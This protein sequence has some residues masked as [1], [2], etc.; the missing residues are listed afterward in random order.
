MTFAAIGTALLYTLFLWWFSTGAI[1][2]LDRRPRSTHRLSLIGV[3]AVA[4][5]AVGALIASLG[6]ATPT[7]AM[8]GFTAAVLIWGWHELSFLTGLITGPRTTICPPDAMGWRRFR[9]AASTLIH[10]EIAL[11]LTAVA[12][13]V[14]SWGQ[15][16]P[17]GALTFLILFA[18]RLSAKLNLFLGVPNFTES[19]L[20]EHLRHLTT[21]MKKGPAS[22]LLP[23][24][25]TIG[26]TVAGLLACRALAAD[27][28]AFDVTAFA[29]MFAL[30][31]LAMLEHA[32]MA[33]P[34]PDAALWRWALPA[35]EKTPT[36]LPSDS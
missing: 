3:S 32:F 29:L 10:H 19:F 17:V 21:Y 15:P 16:N 5:L 18:C 20:P 25:A 26:C 4:L 36:P 30:L 8:M 2:W 22:A 34:L 33:L 35:S 13:G 6:R 24:S 31:A 28:P 7:G 11:A 23:V 27:A 12:L 1:L 9:F 14:V